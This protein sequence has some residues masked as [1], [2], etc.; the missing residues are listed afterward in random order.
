MVFCIVNGLF[1]SMKN[2][3]Q[4]KI[5]KFKSIYS[6]KK[7]TSLVSLVCW[8]ILSVGFMCIYVYICVCFEP[9]G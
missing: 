6:S 5:N 7:E 3:Y 8:N 2:E 1:Y 9:M 4:K